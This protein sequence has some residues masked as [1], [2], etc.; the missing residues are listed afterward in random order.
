MIDTAKIPAENSVWRHKN[1]NEYL[2][3]LVTNLDA[4]AD[5]RDEFPP[6][7]AYRRLKDGTCWSRPLDKWH[8]SFT[9]I[10]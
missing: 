4:F 5:R 7:I 9:E 6:T 3:L 10:K 8:G 1:G 2:V